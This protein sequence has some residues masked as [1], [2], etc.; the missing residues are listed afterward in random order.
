VWAIVRRNA[1]ALE[2]PS[3]VLRLSLVAYAW[4][5]FITLANATTEG[6]WPTRGIDAGSTFAV[7]ELMAMM[8][9]DTQAYYDR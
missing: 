4:P 5:R 1:L 3:A 6:L 8:L 7:Y 2:Y 9:V